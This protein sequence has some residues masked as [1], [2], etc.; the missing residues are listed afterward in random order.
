MDSI[1]IDTSPLIYYLDGVEPYATKV[2]QFLL[3]KLDENR[4]LYTSTITDAEY[5]VHPYRDYNYIKIIAYKSF[6]QNIL[7]TEEL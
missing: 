3:A 4:P 6:I 2:E 1:F 5:L 7:L